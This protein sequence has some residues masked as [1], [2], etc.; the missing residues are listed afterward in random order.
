MQTP[1]SNSYWVVDGLLL[2]GEYP[3]G[4]GP[5]DTRERL[6]RFLDAGIRVF[7]DLTER[8][9]LQPYDSILDDVAAER[10]VEAKYERV[11]IRNRHIPDPEQVRRLLASIGESI[12]AGLACYVHCW[13]GIGRTGTIVGCWLIERQRLSGDDALGRIGKLRAAT[14]HGG[15][16][17]PETDEQCA[18][19]TEWSAAE[20]EHKP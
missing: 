4:A 11:P 1:I 10:G 17:S 19:V 9:E 5:D 14:P 3:G 12:D 15:T 13:G 8:G 2:A 18:F 16:A 6:G 20:D 7:Y